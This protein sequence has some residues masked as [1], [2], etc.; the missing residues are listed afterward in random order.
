M[1]E[2]EAQVRKLLRMAKS[3]DRLKR[4]DAYQ[5]LLA[6]LNPVLRYIC[7]KYGTGLDPDDLKSTTHIALLDA[8][9]HYQPNKGGAISFISMILKRKIITLYRQRNCYRR[10][11]KNI[12]SMDDHDFDQNRLSVDLPTNPDL[13]DDYTKLWR[14]LGLYLTPMRLNIVKLVAQGFS[15]QEIAQRMGKT[16]KQIDNYLQKARNKIKQKLG[17]DYAQHYREERNDPSPEH[18]G[19]RNSHLGKRTNRATTKRTETE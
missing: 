19:T 18:D 3:K 6:S 16:P 10:C 11:P 14:T 17:H 1:D 5:S 2:N 7:Q 9:E 8:V 4:N 15:Y 13:A 12:V